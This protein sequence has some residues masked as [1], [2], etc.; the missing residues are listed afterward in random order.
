M[1]WQAVIQAGYYLQVYQ[2]LKTQGSRDAAS[3]KARYQALLNQVASALQP[4]RRE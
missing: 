2:N 3:A 4:R 1:E